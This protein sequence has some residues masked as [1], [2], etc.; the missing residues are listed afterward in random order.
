MSDQSMEQIQL[1][2]SLDDCKQGSSYK[3]EFQLDEEIFETE[4]TKCDSN[5]TH[6]DFSKIFICNFDFRK[7]QF[8]ILKLTRWKD[9]THFSVHTLGEKYKLTLSNLVTAKDSTYTC[10]ANDKLKNSEKITIKVES[11]NYSQHKEKNNFTF[12]DYIKAGIKL[13]SIIGIDFTQGSEHGMDE[14]NNQYLQAIAQFREIMF[15]YTRDF[16]VYGYGAKFS[17]TNQKPD[18]FNLNLKDKTPL[19]GYT[20][21]EKAYKECFKKINYCDND[22]LS[23]L[24]R[25][26]KNEIELNYKDKDYYIFLLLISNPPKKEDIQKCIDVLIE[27]T[28]L[29]LSV[30]AIGIGDK[31]FKDIKNIFSHKH[32]FSSREVE[33]MRNN[34]YFFP[35]KDFNFKYDLALSECLKEIP[36]QLVEYYKTNMASPDDIRSKNVIN[37][38]NSIKLLESK[39]SC[40]NIEDD[41]APPSY[42]EFS[43]K[44]VESQKNESRNFNINQNNNNGNNG[45]Q[46]E[47]PFI[48]EIKDSKRN[49][50]STPED[51]EDGKYY[52]NINNQPNENQKN[53]NNILN[54]YSSNSNNIKNVEKSNNKDS[55]NNKFPTPTD[56]GNSEEEKYYNYI[57]DNRMASNDE[58]QKKN[59]YIAN[60]FSSNSN[61]MN[62]INEFKEDEKEKVEDNKKEN[63]NSSINK[64]S[65][66]YDNDNY[67]NIIPKQED[68][69]FCNKINNND[70]DVKYYNKPHK[71]GDKN[72]N[73]QINDN[74]EDEKDKYYNKIS[75]KNDLKYKNN[76]INTNNEEKYYNKPTPEP[77]EQIFQNNQYQKHFSNNN[78]NPFQKQALNNINNPYQKQFSNK[79]VNPFQKPSF[80]NNNNINNNDE[81]VYYNKTPGDKED[82]KY[83]NSKNPYNKN[84]NLVKPNN[85]NEED[86]KFV[87]C[88]P[89][90]PKNIIHK[91]NPFKSGKN[92]NEKF[93]QNQDFEIRRTQTEKINQNRDSLIGNQFKQSLELIKKRSSINDSKE[94]TKSSHNSYGLNE[95]DKN[96]LSGSNL[97]YRNDYGRDY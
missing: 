93:R 80:N 63:Y 16:D 6:I 14:K 22:S 1:T 48:N 53:Y 64:I 56:Q 50:F 26:I 15:C 88:T 3:I 41:S 5:S 25:N 31:D 73:N 83:V 37:I 2:F 51:F 81:N 43:I 62:K 8:F 13:K 79:D 69:K 24:I 11:P 86:E 67:Y 91:D 57:N 72:Y 96:K 92:I 89:K 42:L 58:N 18:Y 7:I 82:E 75:E 78:I 59:N 32:K 95:D 44:E 21:V 28:Y 52:N 9:K 76:I 61:N 23:P 97:P 77:G 33:K 54:P 29:P 55:K 87:N 34:A 70:D 20:N 19:H 27:T 40:F 65:Y 74:D 38:N 47:K 10:L 66:N 68:D 60:P 49:K 85:Q 30:V 71:Q 17:D 36:K 45:F 39:R 46:Y 4:K 12:F 90:E 94:S 35:L 84:N